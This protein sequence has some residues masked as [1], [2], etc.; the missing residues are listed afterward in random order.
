ME[1]LPDVIYITQKNWDNFELR[2]S[3]R[4]LKNLPHRDVYVISSQKIPRLSKKVKRVQMRDILKKKWYNIAQ[5]YKKICWLKWVED[6]IT[7]DDDIYILHPMDK[8]VPYYKC[9]LKE[10]YEDR[11]KAHGPRHWRVKTLRHAYECFPKWLSYEVHVPYPM[12]RSI[13]QELFKQNHK[14][15]LEKWWIQSIYYNFAGILWVKHHDNKW[16]QAGLLKVEWEDF[17][18]TANNAQKD[19]AIRNYLLGLFPDKCE[20]E[21]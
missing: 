14:Y 17:L 16:F 15:H 7:I 21:K 13:L 10:H 1:H 2:M 8:I 4:S 12:K 9:P 20:Y 5:G 19:T 18:S 3:L 6:F 11:L